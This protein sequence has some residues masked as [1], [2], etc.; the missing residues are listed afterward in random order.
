MTE[1]TPLDTLP[2]YL[3]VLTLSG[4]LKGLIGL[5]GIVIL[6]YFDKFYIFFRNKF[7]VINSYFIKYI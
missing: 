1:Q 5:I 6:Y 4:E 3:G 7:N 2:F